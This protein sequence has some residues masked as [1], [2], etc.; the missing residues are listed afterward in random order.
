MTD[1]R[2]P[3]RVVNETTETEFFTDELDIA[4]AYRDRNEYQRIAFYSVPPDGLEVLIGE[5]AAHFHAREGS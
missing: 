5:S 4:Q 3:I 1:R 2:N